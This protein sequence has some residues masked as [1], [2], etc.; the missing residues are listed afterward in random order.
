MTNA[1]PTGYPYRILSRRIQPARNK[2]TAF[3]RAKGQSWLSKAYTHHSNTP[4]VYTEYIPKEISLVCFVLR[5]FIACG[6][7]AEVVHAPATY[8]IIVMTSISS[9]SRS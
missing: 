4:V 6:R 9:F 5:I 3:A 8:P 7:N 1:R 2:V